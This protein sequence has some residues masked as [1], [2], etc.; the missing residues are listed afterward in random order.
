MLG[1]VALMVLPSTPATGGSLAPGHHDAGAALRFPVAAAAPAS[2]AVLESVMGVTHRAQGNRSVL[3]LV[4]VLAALGA[5]L[6]RRP[7]RRFGHRSS[8]IVCVTL[9][10]FRGRAPPAS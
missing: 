2:P 10:T 4:A 9:W 5:D 3:L 6:F 1:L 7:L 8:R